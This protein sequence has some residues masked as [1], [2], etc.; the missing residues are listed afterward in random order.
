MGRDVID[1]VVRDTRKVLQ[2]ILPLI[3]RRMNASAASKD[4]RKLDKILSMV[5]HRAH[6]LRRTYVV[7]MA[8]VNARRYEGT[9]QVGVL[10][11]IRVVKLERHAY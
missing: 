9:E 4:C 6:Q 2:E 5:S 1:V 10:A 7:M 8:V 3:F 11:K